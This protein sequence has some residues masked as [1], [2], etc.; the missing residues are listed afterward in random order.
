M[1]DHDDSRR[2][3]L[4][5]AAGQGHDSAREADRTAATAAEERARATIGKRTLAESWGT[6]HAPTGLPAGVGK[7]TLAESWGAAAVPLGQNAVVCSV[8]V[9]AA[10]RHL[11]ALTAS[12][13][14]GGH[15]AAADAAHLLRLALQTARDFATDEQSAALADLE[16]E[17]ARGLAA[18]SAP[19]SDANA[20]TLPGPGRDLWAS[21]VAAREQAWTAAA[22]PLAAQLGVDATIRVDDAAASHG[23]RGLARAG[24]VHLAPTLAPEHA[25]ARHILA[26]ELVHVA[27]SRLPV[28]GTLA[29]AE[30][31]ADELAAGLVRGE[32]LHRPRIGIAA[33]VAAADTGSKAAPRT[34][35]PASAAPMMAAKSD[36]AFAYLRANLPAFTE[37]WTKRLA[38]IALPPNPRIAWAPFGIVTAFA[39]ALAGA[40]GAD[41]LFL[42]LPELM[43]P[44]SPWAVIDQNRALDSGTPGV[45]WGGRDPAGPLTWNPMAGE[46]LAIEL[47]ARV[48]ESI[49]RLVPRYVVQLDA[50]QPAPVTVAD[51]V[52]SQPLDRVT[53][54][55]LCDAR[56]LAP[57]APKL[58]AKA[59]HPTAPGAFREGVRFLQNYRWLGQTDPKLWN[60]IEVTEP[61][62]ATAEEVAATLWLDAEESQRAY[63]ITASAPLFRVEPGH[64]RVLLG[65]LAPA[66]TG[67]DDPHAD[68]ALDVAASGFATD[69][70]IA[71][72]AGER[73]LDKHGA[74]VP[75][76]VHRLAA[77]LDLGWR[78]LERVRDLLVPWHLSELIVPA[79]HWVSSYREHLLAIPEARLIA[80]APVIDGQ[81]AILFEA[82]G[83]VQELVDTL[84]GRSASAG[85]EGPLTALRRS[86]TA[87]VGA[88]QDPID[89]AG[90][91][92]PTDGPEG[93]ITSV[94]RRYATA[95]GES[96]LCEPA[97]VELA[98]ARKAK[99]GLALALMDGSLHA[100]YEATRDL[101]ANEGTMHFDGA[102]SDAEYATYQRQ[103]VDLRG[104][105]AEGTPIDGGDVALLAANLKE[106]A[107]EAKAR[108]LYVQ[109][110]NLSEAIRESM[111]G[112]VEALA[113]LLGGALRELPVQIVP[114]LSELQDSVI[115][116]QSKEKAE[117]MGALGPG[118]TKAALAA[119]TNEVTLRAEQRYA[120]LCKAH[121]LDT[122]IPRAIAL[123]QD[124]LVRT[125]VFKI[126]IQVA[127][128]IGVSILG[129]VA[130]NLVA[131][132][133][134]G[135]LLAD[136]ATASIGM[137]RGARVAEIGSTVL[138]IATDASI[139]T[140]GQMAMTGGDFKDGFFENFATNA[141]LRVL[142]APLHSVAEAWGSAGREVEN[143]SLWERSLGKTKLVLREG[144]VLTAEMITGAAVDYVVK[145]SLSDGPP[146]DEGTALDW[147]VQGASMAAG[148]FFGHKLA[149]FEHD[150]VQLAEQGTHLRARAARL[151]SV[152]DRAA[153]TGDRDAA[154]QVFVEHHELMVEEAKVLEEL[155][156]NPKTKLSA[157][158]I[159][160]LRTGNRAELTGVKDKAFA[161]LPLRFAGLTP[162]DA[163]GKVWAG[164]TEDI[165]IAL[166]QASRCGMHVEV[167]DHKVA[168]RTWV[169][170]FNE[171]QIT[172]IETELRGRPRE[173]KAEI[174][175]ADRQH[176][177]R[178]AAAADYM[179]AKWEAKTKAAIDRLAAPSFDLIQIGGAGAGVTNQ[180]T[181]PATGDGLGSKLTVYDHAGTLS[182]RGSQE[183]GQPPEKWDAP[184]MRASEQAG[185]DDKWL[186]SD[187]LDRTLEVGRLE[188]QTPAYRGRVIDTI[189]RRGSIAD[190]TAWLEPKRAF[191]IK[192]D[193]GGG[194]RYFYADRI[195]YAGGPGA[196]D[197]RQIH[198]VT[199]AHELETM[200]KDERVLRAE[201]PAYAKKVHGGEI[202]VW[203]G[204]ATG[205]WAAEAARKTPDASV[206]VMGDTRPA[207]TD[208]PR[209]VEDYEA[210]MSEIAARGSVPPELASRK[211][212]L[213]T[214]IAKAH[215]G[216]SIA[217]NRK[218]GATYEHGIHG[219]PAHGLRIE[220]GTPS[221]MSPTADGRVMVTMGHG[222]DA[223]TK[224]YDQVV[225]A[226]GLDPATPGGPG[227]LLGAGAD[228][229][230][231]TQ[232]LD[233]VPAGTIALRPVF[234]PH[235]DG[236]VPEVLALESIDPPGIRLTGAAYAN[237]KMSAW[238]KASERAAFEAA[239]D[240]MADAHAMTRDYG[241]VSSD[242]TT[243]T[244]GVE[245]QRDRIPRGNEV[246]AA[247]AYRLPGHDHVLEL[248]KA[249]PA[250]WDDQVREFFT[251]ELRANRE[252]VRVERLGGGRSGAVVYNVWVGD[253]DVGVFKIFR[254][255]AD[256]EMEAKMLDKLKAAHLKKLK[257]VRERGVVGVDD[258][259]GSGALL[260]DA[261]KG[262]SVA[263]M[264]ETLPNDPAERQKSFAR[265][266]I[267]VQQVAEG[268]AEM[269]ARFETHQGGTVA[270]MTKEA[271]LSDANYM[272]DRSFRAGADVAAVRAALGERDFDSVKAK[273]E[274]P[275]LHAFLDARVPAT[276]YHGD[277][278]AGNFILS[279]TNE[280]GRFAEV[281]VIDLDKMRYS[282]EEGTQ[283]ATRTGA[284]DVARFLGSLETLQPGALSPVEVTGLREAFSA[285]Y[286]VQYRKSAG[287]DLDTSQYAKAE[288]WY[289]AE[290]EVGRLKAD[291]HAK[292]RLMQLLELEV[293]P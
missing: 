245:V 251:L 131:G 10:R 148:K 155:G 162:D 20:K 285:Q 103:L 271:K 16:A 267:A 270:M 46:A 40:L 35:E 172:I 205:A 179:Q 178:Y 132:A 105:Y 226:H 279:G 14:A 169:V 42:R 99:G 192:V 24:V 93:A 224:I 265:L 217:R 200:F 65:D 57:V 234:G 26:H 144:V 187:D 50:N 33:S 66:P 11:A 111:F 241:E 120:D 32:L 112:G 287:H 34:I 114:M 160:T 280:D 283:A 284:A 63:I 222:T 282:I 55:L 193:G 173:S 12:Q 170:W 30:R 18:A 4:K 232:A 235:K 243:V 78:Q 106:H 128:L 119:V 81:Q 37:A 246:L 138:G 260:M 53:A 239:V 86:L 45:P 140:L 215:G 41:P 58:G 202:L 180:S 122:L 221:K 59:T 127:V 113:S 13:Q 290:L 67:L 84:G 189:E 258:G 92:T 123:M 100:S 1:A 161:A 8:A 212:A 291:V 126:V 74:P 5:R 141:A 183:L 134:R 19:S 21:D 220:F 273:L 107:F 228:K 52:T 108:T 36:V 216:M 61:R 196:S 257:P 51:V 102:A 90:Q 206:T 157:Q 198:A 207:R 210:V 129:G 194:T 71:Q 238:V 174:T 203:G 249:D 201:D 91:V 2:E 143:A 230:A 272:L 171:E 223:T 293:T 124:Q 142:L 229:N 56:V 209:L 151:K 184:G 150:M 39:D 186:K 149:A 72:A 281:A 163:S 116:A 261:A 76:D 7:T 15:D 254:S 38:V 237:K 253:N 82:V 146:P 242:S 278:N 77:Q 9:D 247:Q 231:Q 277:A 274:G 266:E 158:T 98:G 54:R 164:A 64:A 276:N 262:K 154:L 17:A 104:K 139:N 121:A 3:R 135:T 44:V 190:A 233:E 153:R 83:A 80:L 88:A 159:E 168:A 156:S 96:H 94:L 275:M 188:V 110:H 182:N 125:A 47:V 109:L 166:H 75:P 85:G 211:A 252:W 177:R 137:L 181:L 70:A 264:I 268:L 250:K 167:I 219:D 286:G 244:T 292:A 213:E 259:K 175:D 115:A 255:V 69:V 43:Y 28:A 60:W 130:G 165:A 27:Q 147:A 136:A 48:A 288:T 23:A 101:K 97:R 214:E 49:A 240:R 199:D 6:T 185:K 25:D 31:E 289:R 22:A 208:W 95:I 145:R 68:N 269:H 263:Q 191:R 176:A 118:A 152:A 29:D 256:A 62:D 227:A 79:L 236:D 225:I 87:A 197:L 195:D 73:K 117:R 133:V 218:P 248:D 204:T 89:T